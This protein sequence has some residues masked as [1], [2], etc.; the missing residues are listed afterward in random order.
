MTRRGKFRP[1]SAAEPRS[2]GPSARAFAA[3]FHVGGDPDSIHA[4]DS[5]GVA[6]ASIQGLHSLGR[7]QQKDIVRLAREVTQAR[8]RLARMKRTTR[9]NKSQA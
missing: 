5:C 8:Q 9:R 4:V 2:L 7:K 1:L 6:L 3:E